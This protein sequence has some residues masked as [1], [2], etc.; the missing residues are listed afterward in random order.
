MSIEEMSEHTKTNSTF[1]GRL[2]AEEWWSRWIL[3]GLQSNKARTDKPQI[4][5]I[6]ISQRNREYPT[7]RGK[8]VDKPSAQQ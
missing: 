2:E 8:V 1:S 5:Q 6:R 7:V 4:Y 3:G